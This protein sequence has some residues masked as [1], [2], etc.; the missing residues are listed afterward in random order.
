MRKVY[1]VCILVL[2]FG[3]LL[4]LSAEP[5]QSGNEL[6]FSHKL[7]SIEQEIE[8]ITCHANAQSSLT[9]TDNLMPE[10]ET[11]ADCHDVE[12]DESCRLCHSDAGNPRSV[13]RIET[14]SPKFSHK[15]HIDGKL[16]CSDCHADIPQ[17]TSV[18]PFK[19]PGMQNCMDCH[20][21]KNVSTECAV[22]HSPE[23]RLKPVSHIPG[24]IHN[25]SD[26]AQMNETAVSNDM[27]CITCHKTEFCQNCH[28]GD[29]LDRET[30]P[31][32][33]QFTHALSAQGKVQDCMVCHTERQFCNDCHR[34]NQIL[35]HTHT[36]GWAMPN[37]GG[38]HTMEAESDLESCM[39]CHE[40][41]AEQICQPCH[42]N[43]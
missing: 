14:F 32:N 5:D 28:E 33:F 42:K 4:W 31:L 18:D 26:L 20:Q 11:C 2:F 21:S 24:F 41:N 27:S 22:C 7:H 15:K 16:N 9:G 13:S 43:K 35:P 8:C 6:K 40:Q 34:V 12:D 30:H 39:T 17:K 37:I 3:G 1:V 23:D 19:L 36:A 10:M 25:H 29:N 38:R